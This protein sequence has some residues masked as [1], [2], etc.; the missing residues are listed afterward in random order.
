MKTLPT[1]PASSSAFLLLGVLLILGVLAP[2]QVTIGDNVNMNLN[3][4]LSAGYTA[5]YGNFVQ[6]DHGVTFGGDLDLD[7]YYYSPGFVSFTVNPFYNQ[8]RANS[9]SQSI[10]GSSGVNMGANIFSGSHFPGSITYSKLYTDSG[11]FGFPGLPNYT[12][13]GNSDAFGIGWSENVPNLPTLAASYQQGSNDYT[14]YGENSSSTNSFHSLNLTSSYQWSG[15]NLNGG[16]NHSQAHSEFPSIFSD[17][18]PTLS[19]NSAN[20]Y[21][22]GVGHA[23]PFD[24]N[25]SATYNHS[26]YDSTYLLPGQNTPTTTSG[27]VNAVTG[28]LFFTPTPHLST[29]AAAVYTTNLFG[30]LYLPLISSGGTVGNLTPAQSAHSLNVNEYANYA[31]SP[32]ITISGNAQELSQNYIDGTISSQAYTGTVSYTNALWGGNATVLGGVSANTSSN[33]EGTS[34]G[35]IGSGSYSRDFGNWGLSGS[36]NYAQNTQTALAGYTTSN[37]G[38]SFNISRLLGRWHWTGLAN[39]SKTLLNNTG[40][41][42]F[43]QTYST[44]FSGRWLGVTASYTNL[45][46]NAIL[47]GSGLQPTPI[48]PVILPSQLVFYGGTG[49]GVGIGAT[50]IRRLSLSATYSSSHSDTGYQTV[51]S[52]NTNE[53]LVITSQYQF[54]Q[55]YFNAGFT[56]L[57]QGFSASTL[58]PSMLGSWYVG[59]QRW[60]NFF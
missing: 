55:L 23:L 44:S 5:D 27:S 40:Y 56:R 18:T 46:G 20:S 25:F 37:F 30:F 12:T 24:G 52:N 10:F 8:S 11:T 17:F 1:P 3:G 32:H 19:D 59:I 38:Y 33:T 60:F 16:F 54:R 6:S 35:G 57:V 7:G 14:I 15:F 47:V 4:Q 45:S 41:S 22:A 28:N 9:S 50:P 53:T 43:G 34:V 29:G 39:G 26:A 49:W 31:F 58:P 51:F 36:L 42:N 2:A 48:P 13:K 21:Y